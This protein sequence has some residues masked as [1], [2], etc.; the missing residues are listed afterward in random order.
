MPFS[1]RAAA[2]GLTQQVN[3]NQPLTVQI[4]TGATQDAEFK[5][6]P[7]Y[8]TPGSITASVADN[9]LTVSGI[10]AGSLLPGQVLADVTDALE[11]GTFIQRQLSGDD[12]GEGTYEV[13]PAG[14]TVPSEAMTTSFGLVGNV[15][16]VVAWKDIQQ[17]DALNIQGT[18]YK[19]YLYGRVEAIV[20]PS[21]DGGDIITDAAGR[22]YLVA[23]V[24]EQWP[25]IGVPQWCAV[26]ATLQN[27]G[28]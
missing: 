13:Y 6:T 1:V 7:S 22:K 14:Q 18:R 19:I 16:P 28:A 8:A 3:P 25:P 5:D 2:N 27:D 10:S 20:R 15:Q 26:A 11:A 12:G 21:K 9:I 17:L 23:M 24:F 4:S